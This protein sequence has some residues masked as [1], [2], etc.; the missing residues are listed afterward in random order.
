MPRLFSSSSSGMI[1]GK[2]K[3]PYGVLFRLRLYL[4]LG[5]YRVFSW[6]PDRVKKMVERSRG[7]WGE[8]CLMPL[9]SVGSHH[10]SS[11]KKRVGKKKASGSKWVIRGGDTRQEPHPTKQ[12]IRRRRAHHF[13]FT[14]FRAFAAA[15]PQCTALRCTALHCK[16]CSKYSVIEMGIIESNSVVGGDNGM[17]GYRIVF[18]SPG[19]TE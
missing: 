5:F 12:I 14:S 6:L 13:F 15:V 11:P 4:D 7:W 9:A 1:L 2:R 10:F 17:H 3:P 8:G 16:H 18:S 19:F